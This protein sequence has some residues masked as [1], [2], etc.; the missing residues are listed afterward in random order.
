MAKARV[1]NLDEFDE[2]IEN[3]FSLED[4]ETKNSGNRVE[5]DAIKSD[6]VIDSV[7]ISKITLKKNL[8]AYELIFDNS[9]ENYKDSKVTA[10]LYKIN[11]ERINVLSN[12][13]PNKGKAD[14][15]NY[16]VQNF[17][18]E[19]QKEI[20]KAHKAYLQTI[21]KDPLNL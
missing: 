18:K 15:L 14:L 13:L 1:L 12:L 17:F 6:E 19:N 8:K 3:S 20:I 21:D 5:E 11:S 9:L 10:A 16:I 2:R 7:E 4:V